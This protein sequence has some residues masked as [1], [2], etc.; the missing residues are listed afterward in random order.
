MTL[1]GLRRETK[2]PRLESVALMAPRREDKQILRCA[3]DDMSFRAKRKPPTMAIALVASNLCNAQKSTGPRTEE[4]KRRVMFLTQCQRDSIVAEPRERMPVLKGQP[5]FLPANPECGWESIT[6]P[7]AGQV[8]SQREAD[9]V[10]R[11]GSDPAARVG[12]SR[13]ASTREGLATRK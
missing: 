10:R 7:G 12:S 5:G 2:S 3:Q 4:G 11:T 1:T 8:P 6:S 13:P 9:L